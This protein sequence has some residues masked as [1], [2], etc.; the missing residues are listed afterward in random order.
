MAEIFAR[1]IDR[2]EHSLIH[3]CND[4]NIAHSVHVRFVPSGER[5]YTLLEREFE[6]YEQHVSRAETM[7]DAHFGN[8]R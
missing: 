7:L 3:V 8:I 1:K 2:H 4:R 5:D 6:P